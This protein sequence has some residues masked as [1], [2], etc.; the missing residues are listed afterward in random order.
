MLV[1]EY[2]DTALVIDK[3]RNRQ[4]YLS[5]AACLFISLIAIQQ[6]LTNELAWQW[7]TGLVAMAITLVLVST[8]R[9]TLVAAGEGPR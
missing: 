6:M 1:C 5:I 2:C 4:R 9:L 7:G 8:R 3:K